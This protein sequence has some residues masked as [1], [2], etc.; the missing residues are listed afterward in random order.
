MAAKAQTP[1]TDD[2][3]A[4]AVVEAPAAPAFDAATLAVIE[5]MASKMAAAMVAA[6][7]DGAKANAQALQ[8]MAGPRDNPMG[9]PL[10]STLNPMGDRDHPRPDLKCAMTWCGYDIER[11]MHSVEELTLLN[12][13]E[14]GHYRVMKTD[15]SYGI[16]SVFP[17][18][19]STSNTLRRLD[20]KLHGVKDPSGLARQNWPSMLAI[21]AMAQGLPIPPPPTREDLPL[22]KISGGTATLG[23]PTQASLNGGLGVSMD[24]STEAFLAA[25]KNP[26]IKRDLGAFLGR[27]ATA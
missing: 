26:M 22:G 6:Q 3:T 10:V 2:A 13:I 9:S 21:L 18:I 20:L 16:L 27:E 1:A 25:E 24:T 8:Q 19:D 4:T 11:E 14:P 5:A 7:A 12:S 23:L 15:G 17:S